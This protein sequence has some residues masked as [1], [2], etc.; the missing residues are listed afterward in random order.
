MT[1][2]VRHSDTVSRLGGDEFILVLQEVLDYEALLP[3]AE[4]ILTA[5]AQPIRI[6]DSINRVTASIGIAL[7]PDD[8][9]RPEELLKRAD[10][11]MYYAKNK[12]KNT[13]ARYLQGMSKTLHLLQGAT[14]R[15]AGVRALISI[16]VAPEQLRSPLVRLDKFALPI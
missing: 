3:V 2:C 9:S 13:Y 6:E 5:I 4:K 14:L 10:A 12:G 15:A 11:A 16:N 1:A 8:G 7:A